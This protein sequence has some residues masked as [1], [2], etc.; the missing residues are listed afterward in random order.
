MKK[1]ISRYWKDIL[2]NLPTFVIVFL[3]VLSIYQF[4]EYFIKSDRMAMFIAIII[5]VIVIFCTLFIC[6]I[7]L[8]KKNKE[9][10]FL[11]RLHRGKNYFFVSYA[12][13]NFEEVNKCKEELESEGFDV[14]MDLDGIESGDENFKKVIIPA[15]NKSISFLFFL[16]KE[17]QLSENA[18][19]ELGFAEHKKKHTVLIR[20]NDDNF[21]D[22]FAY[23]YKNKDI[24]DW[25]DSAQRQKLLKDMKKWVEDAKNNNND[26]F[27]KI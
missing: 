10:V 11:S 14:W 3:V 22:E 4:C 18:K 16:T 1:F 25:R 24:I 27:D 19:K 5:F 12:R 15:I 20:I 6:G 13:K 7:M 21:T 26:E 17:S 8:F 23:D 9:K 2:T